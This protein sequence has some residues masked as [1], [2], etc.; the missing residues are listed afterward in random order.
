M[1]N[2]KFLAIIFSAMFALMING[3]SQAVASDEF[4]SYFGLE[5]WEEVRDK[6]FKEVEKESSE[7][8]GKIKDLLEEIKKKKNFPESVYKLSDTLFISEKSEEELAKE[9]VGD[10][11][12]SNILLFVSNKVGCF[13]NYILCRSSGS[14][15]NKIDRSRGSP[16]KMKKS[17]NELYYRKENQELASNISKATD[18]WIKN[19]IANF[20]KFIVEQ[21]IVRPF[22]RVETNESNSNLDP[23]PDPDS[24]LDLDPNP[25]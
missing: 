12:R 13:K 22:L 15:T 21:S 6:L 2:R 3:W 4:S 10:E 5:E 25:D 9:A 17:Y 18:E 24:D 7:P 19:I 8:Y 16:S 11:T 1:E 23:N 20:S 14:Y